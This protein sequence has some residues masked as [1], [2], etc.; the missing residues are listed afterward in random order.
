MRCETTASRNRKAACYAHCCE[1]TESVMTHTVRHGRQTPG[2]AAAESAEPYELIPARYHT[3]A[4]RARVVTDTVCP[5]S[6]TRA[7]RLAKISSMAP[8][9]E[10]SAAASPAP[11]ARDPEARMADRGARPAA[12]PRTSRGNSAHAMLPQYG[13]RPRLLRPEAVA[14]GLVAWRL[15][16]GS[17]RHHRRQAAS[18]TDRIYEYGSTSIVLERSTNYGFIMYTCD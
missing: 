3:C 15:A 10:R 16:R 1:V 6:S 12:R 18:P 9:A 11:R 13:A 7:G 8:P 5:T 17:H 14:D 4:S 2:P